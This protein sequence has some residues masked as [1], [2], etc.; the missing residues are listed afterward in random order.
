MKKIVFLAVCAMLLTA[1][2]ALGAPSPPVNI[3]CE[4]TLCSGGGQRD[5]QY[6][7]QNIWS[8]SLTITK[9][10][11][12]TQDLRIADYSNWTA[13]AGFT[14]AAE[15][16]TWEALGG[17]YNVMYTTETETETP[18]GVRPPQS[19]FASLGGIVWTGNAVIEQGA[20]VTFGFDNPNESW[21]VQWFATN[22]A[23]W[24][25]TGTVFAPIAG[26]TGTFT[27]GYVHSPVPEPATI[28]LF[29]IG[30]FGLLRKRRA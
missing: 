5:Y 11:I 23:T 22:S 21:N 2:L 28:C 29:G 13:P 26:P 16:A 12:G 4:G 14:S 25:V 3:S 30:V 17:N 7:L 18:H 1:G 6:T 20:S 8:D 10:Y 27:G 19:T 15:V 9:F 24:T